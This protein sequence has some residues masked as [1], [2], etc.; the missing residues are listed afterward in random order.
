[1][2]SNDESSSDDENNSFLNKGPLMGSDD[3]VHCCKSFG[4]SA[5]KCSCKMS[6]NLN[7]NGEETKFSPEIIPTTLTNGQIKMELSENNRIPS[8]ASL[9]DS[10]VVNSQSP[11]DRVNLTVVGDHIDEVKQAPDFL[12]NCKEE[13]REFVDSDNHNSVTEVNQNSHVE[14]DDCKSVSENGCDLSCNIGAVNITIDT[15]NGS[16]NQETS[17]NSGLQINSN[18]NNNDIDILNDINYTNDSNKLK[19]KKHCSKIASNLDYNLL[20]G[21]KGIELLTAIEEQTHNSLKKN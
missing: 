1:M 13:T 8:R 19:P 4:R 5:E 2:A 15:N 10:D 18:V 16:L 21:K 6:N 20:K 12:L 9:S 3:C 7:H 11:S 17:K 14:S